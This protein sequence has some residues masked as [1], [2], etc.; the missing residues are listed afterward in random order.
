MAEITTAAAFAEAVT[1]CVGGETLYVTEKLDPVAIYHRHFARP[2]TIQCVERGRFDMPERPETPG[3]GGAWNSAIMLVDVSGIVLQD[4]VATGWKQPNPD[5]ADPSKRG[6]SEYEYRGGGLGMDNVRDVL[7][8]GGFYGQAGLGIGGAGLRNVTIQDARINGS[9]FGIQLSG[10][11]NI[12]T[13]QRSSDGIYILRNRV[14]DFDINAYRGDHPDAIM[15]FTAPPWTE[16]WSPT[17]APRNVKVIENLCV[18]NGPNQPQGIF[19]RDAGGSYLMQQGALPIE[20]R[21]ANA[22]SMPGAQGFPFEDIEIS[23]NIVAACMWN[24]ISWERVD[25]AAFRVNEN[26]VGHLPI[27]PVKYAG[28]PYLVN[29]TSQGRLT[30]DCV[31]AELLRN[32]A[33]FYALPM[34]SWRPGPGELMAGVAPAGNENLPTLTEAE[35]NQIVWEWLSTHAAGKIPMPDVIVPPTP[36]PAPSP[37]PS[38]TPAPSVDPRVAEV[39]TLKAQLAELLAVRD[40]ASKQITKIRSRLRALAKQGFA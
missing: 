31:P 27:D 37:T 20:Q 1:K 3:W 40:P 2:L 36:A 7:V 22:K 17:I 15:I 6:T 19:F 34:H 32:K 12:K 33:H 30:G 26:I 9:N 25:P 23:R 8:D 21:D 29:A 13:G 38:P 35:F 24:H 18:G 10:G 4:V 5:F 39:R 14:T 11:G 16:D 28:H